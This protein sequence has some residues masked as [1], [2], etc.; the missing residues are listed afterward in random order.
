MAD[1]A[2][3]TLLFVLVSSLVSGCGEL[4]R[5]TTKLESAVVKATPSQIEKG[6]VLPASYIVTFKTAAGGPGLDFQ[7]YQAEFRRH[8]VALAE[9]FLGDPRVKDIRFL[10]GVD[11]SPV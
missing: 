4:H 11:L 10:T 1:F 6:E 5:A 3:K 9:S 7:N 8:Y 2:W